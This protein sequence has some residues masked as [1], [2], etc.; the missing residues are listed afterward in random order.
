MQVDITSLYKFAEIFLDTFNFFIITLSFI[1]INV[2]L[3]RMLSYCQGFLLHLSRVELNSEL[4]TIKHWY[5]FTVI[6]WR[7]GLP[8]LHCASVHR[9]LKLT[10]DLWSSPWRHRRN[11][12]LLHPMLTCGFSQ[13][14]FWTLR[15]SKHTHGCNQW[16]QRTR[17]ST[18]LSWSSLSATRRW[19]RCRSGWTLGTAA[20]NTEISF[21]IESTFLMHP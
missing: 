4:V 20:P 18:Q 14:L 6:D 15:S 9:L 5:W 8:Q 17:Q 21:A 11:E 1:F 3:C 2:Q 19:P 12:L 16:F 10:G 13:T 7:L